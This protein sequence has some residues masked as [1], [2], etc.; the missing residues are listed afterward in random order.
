MGSLKIVMMMLTTT[1]ARLKRC[2]ECNAAIT[3]LVLGALDVGQ[4][5]NIRDECHGWNV[6]VG[7]IHIGP[8]WR[9]HLHVIQQSLN[10]N[11]KTVRMHRKY[12]FE[13]KKLGIP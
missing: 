11:Q 13:Y 4:Q 10:Y 9:R 8:R 3:Q 1:S 6:E 2:H 12:E 7:S 5:Q